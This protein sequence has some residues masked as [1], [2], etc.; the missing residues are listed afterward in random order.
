MT[1][2]LYIIGAGSHA[3]VIVDVANSNKYKIKCLVDINSKNIKNEKKFGIP[4]NNSTYLEKIK[5]NSLVFLAIGDNEIRFNY[6]K[7]FRGKFNFINLISKSSQISKNSTLGKG[8]YIGPNV[9]INGGTNIGNNCILNTSSVIEHDVNIGDNI[10]ICP[11][12]TIGGNTKINDNCFIGLGSNIIDKI[13]IGKN[14]TL[15]AGSLVNKN[16][17]TNSTYY[18]SP[19]KKID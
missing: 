5:K 13:I 12:V 8:N 14:V 4:V 15:G 9:V 1:N 6:F 16:L 11:S 3:S 10:H 17:E 2:S 19:V 7:K 18:G